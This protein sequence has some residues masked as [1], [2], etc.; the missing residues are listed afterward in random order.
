MTTAWQPHVLRGYTFIANGERGALL[1]PDGAIV[2]LRMPHW[3]SPAAF[4][5]LLGAARW[6]ERSRSAR[7]PAGLSAGARAG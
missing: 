5:A 7:G 1:A 4:S 3:D 6:L 2:W